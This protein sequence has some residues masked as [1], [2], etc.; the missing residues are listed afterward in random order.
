MTRAQNSSVPSAKCQMPGHLT[1]QK[2]FGW[3]KERDIASQNIIE[4]PKQNV[5]SD[6]KQN[7][8]SDGTPNFFPI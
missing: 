1:C 7:V 2:L 4:L 6:G 3:P 5:N 8:N